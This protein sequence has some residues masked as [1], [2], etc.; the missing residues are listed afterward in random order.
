MLSKNIKRKLIKQAT[1]LKDSSLSQ[2][3]KRHKL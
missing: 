3:I 1:G 2:L